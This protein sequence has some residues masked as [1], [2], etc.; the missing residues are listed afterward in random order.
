[1]ISQTVK[2]FCFLTSAG[3]L[4]EHNVDMSGGGRGGGGSSGCRAIRVAV[5][6]M[7]VLVK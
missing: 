4:W 1:M 7:M 3:D 6:V 5:A 2:G